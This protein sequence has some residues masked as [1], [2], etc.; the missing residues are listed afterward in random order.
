MVNVPGI[1]FYFPGVTGLTGIN[2]RPI[3]A[4]QSRSFV[5]Y[6]QGTGLRLG[7]SSFQ[8]VELSNPDLVNANTVT[9]IVG[10]GIPNNTYD[11][12]IDK[13]VIVT[14][15]PGTNL[16]VQNAP[17]TVVG[18]K[19]R[20]PAWADSIANG[21]TVT[22]TDGYTAHGR[23]A[24]SVCN[25]DTG[26]ALLTLQDAGGSTIATIQPSTAFYLETGGTVKVNNAS[27]GAVSCNICEIYYT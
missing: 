22:V 26:A 11:E 23:K 19:T 16:I 2:A 13:R 9:I 27:G 25:N 12:F 14:N 18:W 20:T 1:S 24:I 5:N 15:Q 17:T 10:G 21:I 4:G 8:K 6:A 7:T 3:N